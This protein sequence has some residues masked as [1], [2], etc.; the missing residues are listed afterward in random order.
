MGNSAL[1]SSFHTAMARVGIN[2]S[3]VCQSFNGPIGIKVAD[4]ACR[5]SFQ[6]RCYQCPLPHVCFP[7][8]CRV[9]FNMCKPVA[10][11][12]FTEVL[13]SD[14]ISHRQFKE[15]GESPRDSLRGETPRDS[16]RGESP[17]SSLRG[18]SPR[19]SLRR[20]SPR[21]KLRALRGCFR[22]VDWNL[23]QLDLE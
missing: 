1:F 2:S 3:S 14:Y 21:D 11:F 17:R 10:R 7:R 4:T 5:H 15:N 8:V 12:Y 16:L 20:K 22:I 19:K 18:E 6:C 23:R 9:I 13:D